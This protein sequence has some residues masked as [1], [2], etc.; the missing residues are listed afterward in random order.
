[1][2]EREA[3]TASLV[4]PGAGKAVE[5]GV[6][7]KVVE[8]GIGQVEWWSAGL[9]GRAVGVDLAAVRYSLHRITQA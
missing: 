1:M 7:G 3:S 8:T 6:G 5:A 9:P 4:R 2:G